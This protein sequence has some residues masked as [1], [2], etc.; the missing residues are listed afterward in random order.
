MSLR[1][2]RALGGREQDERPDA[3]DHT[4][5][6]DG[7]QLDARA[8]FHAPSLVLR[9][10][11]RAAPATRRCRSDGRIERTNA[12]LHNCRRVSI[13]YERRPELYLALVQL[14]CCLIIGRCLEGAF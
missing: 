14:A 11:P 7:Q 8:L 13:R 3:K 5:E 1:T 10:R 9:W 12:W 4:D 6:R 2:P